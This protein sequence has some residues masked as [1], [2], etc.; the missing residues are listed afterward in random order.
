MST[1]LELQDA[2]MLNLLDES[3]RANAKTYINHRYGWILALEE[4]SFLNDTANVTVT[5]G[6]QTVTGLPSDFGIPIGLWDSDGNPLKAYSDWRAFLSRYNAN[7]G[8]SGTSE[9]YTVIGSSMLVGPTPDTTATDF[10]L[11]YELE[12]AA[13][14]ADNEVPI[15]PSL[16]HV[17]LIHGGR[18]EAMK[19]AHN[20]T[21]Q[22]VEQDF[23]ASIDAM[24]R[25]YL[26]GVR[27]T[28]E[29]I[30]AYRP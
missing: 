7:L 14:A 17:A 29:Q 4:W 2:V 20:Q 13:M 22:A 3:D 26:A 16:F 27:S 5:A 12:G 6:S 15:I 24:R 21:W 28:G 30:P 9:A 23:L 10:L 8:D 1:F 18:A 11:A 25:R 19:M